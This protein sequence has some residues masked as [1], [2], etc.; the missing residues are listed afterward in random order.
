VED[1]AFVPLWILWGKRNNRCFEGCE[2]TSE[3]TKSFFQHFV[4]LAV[5]YV[6]HLMISHFDFLILFAPTS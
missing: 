1:G 5:A 4:S 6:S 3:E 2:R